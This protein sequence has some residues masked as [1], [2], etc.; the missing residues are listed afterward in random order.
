MI[1]IS[2]KEGIYVSTYAKGDWTT[3]SKAKWQKKNMKFWNIP[4][5]AEKVK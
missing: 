4:T 1:I 2:L 3:M 5:Y